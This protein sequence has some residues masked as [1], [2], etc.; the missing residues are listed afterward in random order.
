M[1]ENQP[2][3]ELID[4]LEQEQQ[5]LILDHF[6]DDDAL[7]LGLRMLD[8][9]REDELPVVIAVTKGAQSVFRAALPGSVPDFH[10]WVERKAGAVLRFGEPSYLVQL[11]HEARGERFEDRP[12]VDHAAIAGHGGS[13]PIRV[14]GI[15][16][17]GTASVSGL[18]QQADHVLAAR[19]IADLIASSRD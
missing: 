14:D 2:I 10:H 13:V 7:E 11:R 5:E 8:I 15:G 17:V 19:A 6:D 16:I 3:D 18:T 12:D 1:H 4:E 9:A